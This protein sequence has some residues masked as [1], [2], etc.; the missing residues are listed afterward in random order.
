MKPC[1]KKCDL[2]AEYFF[3]EGCF[4]TEVSNSPDD[5]ALSVARA[6]VEPGMTTDW[7]YLEA[8]TERYVIIE[9]SGRVE[10][11]ELAAQIVNAGD[12]VIIPPGVRQRITNTGEQSL[13]FLAICTPRFEAAAYNSM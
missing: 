6:R 4:I 7:H 3:D 11:G 1:I 13:I 10:I 12:T 5:P 8:T 9:G 2:S